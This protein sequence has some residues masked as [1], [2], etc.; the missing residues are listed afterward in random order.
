MKKEI[1]KCAG[2]DSALDNQR[3]LGQNLPAQSENLQFL[4]EPGLPSL[5]LR[6][7]R[8]VGINEHTDDD[9]LPA[10]V[11]RSSHMQ[12][13]LA[14][15]WLNLTI[16]YI[17]SKLTGETRSNMLDCCFFAPQLLA[18][19]TLVCLLGRRRIVNA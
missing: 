8:P 15:L 4:E 17:S 2:S 5:L 13:G 10:H 14:P 9:Q 1:D 19:L 7:D 12:A 18:P 11:P 3:R 16:I 6:H